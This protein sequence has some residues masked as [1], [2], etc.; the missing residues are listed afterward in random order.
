MPKYAPKK[1][2]PWQERLRAMLIHGH[3][4]QALRAQDPAKRLRLWAPNGREL[5]RS[6][7]ADR[8]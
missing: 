4:F 3:S 6:A 5:S 2:T 1:Q 8:G 7:D